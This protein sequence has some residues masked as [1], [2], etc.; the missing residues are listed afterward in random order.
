MLEALYRQRSASHHPVFQAMFQFNDVRQETFDLAGLTMEAVDF[1]PGT[2]ELD[3]ALEVSERSGGLSAVLS[4]N[5]DVF[6]AGAMRRMLDHY[7][8]RYAWR[9][10]NRPWPVRLRQVTPVTAEVQVNGP[11]RQLLPYASLP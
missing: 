6:D 9:E 3:V 7:Q 2:M 8:V 11:R 5:T 4:Y 10:M 1:A